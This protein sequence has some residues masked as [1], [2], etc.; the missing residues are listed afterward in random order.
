MILTGV[1]GLFVHIIIER[2]LVVIA[3]F[4]MMILVG[5]MNVWLIEIML[6]FIVNVTWIGEVTVNVVVVVVVV[7]RA[8]LVTIINMIITDLFMGIVGDL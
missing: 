4:I 7:V 6:P 5:L 8:H 2:F 1:I 3:L